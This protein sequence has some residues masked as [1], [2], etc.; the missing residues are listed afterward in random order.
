VKRVLIY[1]TG[2]VNLLHSGRNNWTVVCNLSEERKGVSVTTCAMWVSLLQ[3]FKK[4][5]ASATF[6]YNT[7]PEYD[8]CTELPTYSNSPAPVYI[9]EL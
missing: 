9:G 5:D 3:D 4:R 1:G 8:S 7:T 2:N 6:Y